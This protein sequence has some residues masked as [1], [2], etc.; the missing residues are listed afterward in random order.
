MLAFP[1]PQFPS[2][3]IGSGGPVSTKRY[4]NLVRQLRLQRTPI[5]TNDIWI[6][7]V[8]FEKGAVL[9]TADR[10]FPV[11]P[12]LETMDYTWPSIS[13]GPLRDAPRQQK[14]PFRRDI[15]GP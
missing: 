3:S 2:G 4:G 10:H 15:E 13:S 1:L 5:P 8:A 14:C 11:I 7:A 9:L 6:A 12:M